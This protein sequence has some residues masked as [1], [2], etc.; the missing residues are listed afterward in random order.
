MGGGLG[1]GGC[2][3]DDV[4]EDGEGL[5]TQVGVD[6]GLAGR[7]DALDGGGGFFVVI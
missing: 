4:A 6:G 1:G 5:G 3:G 2:V 7:V